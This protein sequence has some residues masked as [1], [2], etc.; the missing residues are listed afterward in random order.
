MA[1]TNEALLQGMEAAAAEGPEAFDRY[2]LDHFNELPESVQGAT[3]LSFMRER[4]EGSEALLGV[5]EAA[6]DAMD[7]IERL[8]SELK[9]EGSK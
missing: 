3:L 2:V 8:Q 6:M 1:I 9:K 7:E 5:Q 4:I